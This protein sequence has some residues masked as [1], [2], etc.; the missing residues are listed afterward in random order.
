MVPAL[1]KQFNEAFS[2]EKYEAYINDLSKI[3]PGHLDF[4]VAETPVFIPK[5]FTQKMLDACEAIVDVIKAPEYLKESERAIPPSLRVPTEDAHPQF[6]CFDFGIFVKLFLP[7]IL[8]TLIIIFSHL[9]F[10][11]YMNPTSGIKIIVKIKI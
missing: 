4:R 10:L 6:I 5:W 1:R 3:Y 2:E 8:M 9:I 11:F 7:P